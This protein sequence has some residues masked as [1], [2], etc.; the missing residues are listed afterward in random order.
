MT[1]A[2]G[3][4]LEPPDIQFWFPDPADSSYRVHIVLD[5]CRMLKLIQNYF[6]SYG[7]LKD[8]A[9]FSCLAATADN[10]SW[11]VSCDG[12][13]LPSRGWRPRAENASRAETLGAE[14]EPSG[15]TPLGRPEE[16]DRQIL[17][18]FDPLGGTLQIA[19]G[20]Y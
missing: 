8:D 12:R 5:A 18:M 10:D 16:P 19:K 14:A 9:H 11:F 15:R 2:L 4:K 6:A 20:H 17:N 13:P 3:V 7:I 1:Q